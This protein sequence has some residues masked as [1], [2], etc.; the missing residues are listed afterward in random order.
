MQMR[1]DLTTFTRV[2]HD[3]APK[4]NE[5]ASCTALSGLSALLLS[6]EICNLSAG[7]TGIVPSKK[8]RSVKDFFAYF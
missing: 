3:S 7:D 8:C 6:I 4:W 2:G 1:N 5:C